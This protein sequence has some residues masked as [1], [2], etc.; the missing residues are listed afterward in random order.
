MVRMGW[1]VTTI[2]T[3]LLL[4]IFLAVAIAYGLKESR[5][6]KA[7]EVQAEFSEE[8]TETWPPSPYA[9]ML[10]EEEESPGTPYMMMILITWCMVIGSTVLVSLEFGAL[11]TLLQWESLVFGVFLINRDDRAA[12][13][14]GSIAILI[15]LLHFLTS[16]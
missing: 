12:K 16:S 4:L 9:P 2:V 5:R 7:R 15:F 11:K 6:S 10:E 14:N 8:E 3:F 13:V 1:L